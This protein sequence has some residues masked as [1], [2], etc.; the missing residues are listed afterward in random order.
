MKGSVTSFGNY[1]REKYLLSL[2]KRTQNK[3]KTK[4]IQTQDFPRMGDVVLVKEDLPC[5]QWKL[6]KLNRL[7][8]S[9][10]GQIRSAEVVFGSGKVINRPLN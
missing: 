5:G 10:D 9:R 1:G 4:G 7:R 2:R 3:I 6:D 8:I